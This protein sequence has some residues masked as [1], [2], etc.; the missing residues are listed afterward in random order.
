MMY[1]G[2]ILLT[3]NDLD[4]TMSRKPTKIYSFLPKGFRSIPV[5]NNYYINNTGKMVLKQDAKYLELYDNK[6]NWQGYVTKKIGG[7]DYRLH[8]LVLMTFKPEEYKKIG[9]RDSDGYL[10]NVDH[11]NGIKWDNRIENLEVVSCLENVRRAHE[12]GLCSKRYVPIQLKNYSTGEVVNYKNKWDCSRKTGITIGKIH[13]RMRLMDDGGLLWPEGFVARWGISDEPWPPVTRLVEGFSAITVR[14][15][16]GNPF[17]SKVYPSIEC[18]SKEFGMLADTVRKRLKKERHPVL[19]NLH[20]VKR[21]SDLSEWREVNDPLLELLFL[22][23]SGALK[24]CIGYP[25]VYVS[26]E[27]TP[28]LVSLP[29][30][31][32][33][34]FGIR[35]DDIVKRKVLKHY[36][37]NPK[38][39]ITC[40]GKE[41]YLYTDYVKTNHYTKWKGKMK[42]DIGDSNR[43]IFLSSEQ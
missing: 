42:Y 21:F 36:V 26:D 34:F 1:T 6:P 3:C 28:P 43:K 10:Y 4:N 25:I 32:N 27:N 37:N 24:H 23:D 22:R 2:C 12:I 31:S 33:L 35:R 8:H 38:K 9:T 29:G 19:V 41:F 39:I 20:Q 17:I 5:N 7:R 13:S 16:K 18:Y 15:L 11:V 30:Y 14:D 40:K